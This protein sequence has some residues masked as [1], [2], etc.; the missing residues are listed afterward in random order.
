MGDKKAEH[1][2]AEITHNRSIFHVQSVL[3]FHNPRPLV[4]ALSI[5]SLVGLKI[6]RHVTLIN[7]Q[8]NRHWSPEP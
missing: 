6:C 2:I 8:H 4:S 1:A 7:K 5:V 3:V